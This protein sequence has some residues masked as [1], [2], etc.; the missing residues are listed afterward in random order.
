MST[1]QNHELMEREMLRCE[2]LMRGDT[3]GLAAIVADNLVHVHL[4]GRVDGKS[5]YLHGIESEYRFLDVRRSELKIRG[6]GKFAIMVGRL[7]QVIEVVKSG[8]RIPIEAITTQTWYR[9]NGTWIQA[10]CHNAPHKG[11][12]E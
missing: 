12:S 9:P 4:D 11:S 8:E 10:S 1:M 5:A 7:S 3:N 6:F 2:L